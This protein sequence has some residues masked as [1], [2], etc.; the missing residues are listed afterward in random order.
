MGV[1]ALIVDHVQLECQ[2]EDVGFI[3]SQK[4][5]VTVISNTEAA[6]ISP[7]HVGAYE[8]V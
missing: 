4:T 7:S 1:C 6:C 3:Q 8:E 2:W 5:A